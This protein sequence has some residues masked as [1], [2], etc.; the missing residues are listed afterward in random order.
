MG[1]DLRFVYRHFPLSRLHPH[2]ESA[3]EAAEAAGEQ[4]RFWQMHSLLFENQQTLDPWRLIGL[5]ETLHLDVVRSARELQ[6]HVY[7]NRVR[8]DFLS[9]LNSGVNGSPTFFINGQR[10]DGPWD[11]VG[12]LE[13]LETA[14]TVAV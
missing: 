8:E 6:Q 9:G 2:A 10:Y 14:R 3:A 5:A 4:G 11:L 1:S 7:R 12:L 13:A